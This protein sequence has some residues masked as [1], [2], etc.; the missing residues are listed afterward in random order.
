VLSEPRYLVPASVPWTEALDAWRAGDSRG[1]HRGT[2]AAFTGGKT[3]LARA[4]AAR[5]AESPLGLR[6]AV[7]GR[8]RQPNV[9]APG[10]AMHR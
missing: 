6:L 7:V 4:A 2:A 8:E 10:K 1:F 3:L 5:V 9:L